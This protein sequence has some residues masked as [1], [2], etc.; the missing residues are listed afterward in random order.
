MIIQWNN[1][2]P[3]NAKWQY[4]ENKAWKLTWK[5]KQ[6]VGMTLNIEAHEFTLN[7]NTNNDS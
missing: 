4:V 1:I 5:P 3:Q 6:I 7:N 2:F